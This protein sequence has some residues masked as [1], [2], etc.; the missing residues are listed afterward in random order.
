[1]FFGVVYAGA[2]YKFGGMQICG[3]LDAL[4]VL[5]VVAGKEEEGGSTPDSRYTQ[6]RGLSGVSSC[7]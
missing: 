7:G 4:A 6:K 2:A 1:M 3:C 5:W